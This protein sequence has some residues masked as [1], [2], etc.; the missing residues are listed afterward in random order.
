MKV[1]LSGGGTGGHIYPALTIA[2]AIRD[3]EPSAEIT[4]VGTRKGLEKDIIPRYGYPLEFIEVAGFERHLGLGTLKSAGKLVVGL[5]EAYQLLNRINPDLVIGT[6][7][8]VCGPIL[9]WAALKR[10]PTA[11]QE[12]NAMPGVTNKILSRFVDEVFLGYKEGARYFASHAKKIFTGNPVRKE[13]LVAERSAGI[14]KFQ[15]DPSRKTLLVFGGSRGAR[16]INQSMIAV[17]K[18]L[19]GDRHIQILHATGQQGYQSHIEALGENLLKADNLHIVPYLHD[20]PL[21]LAA[22]DVAVSRAGAIGLAELMVKG[23][24]S[25]LIPYPY[26]TAN[27]QEFNARALAALGAAKVVLDKDLSGEILLREVESLLKDEEVLAMMHRSACKAGMPQAAET[28]AQEALALA[29][30]DRRN[31]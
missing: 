2:D 28:I 8:Y 14:A 5:S 9:F 6:G 22:A 16:S 29:E 11:I 18:A 24:P 7:G 20:M 12:Q 23:I 26:A 10:V 27:H 21:A 4:F 13:I 30:R 19:A 17:E 15:L 1:I 3:L 31:A 25:I